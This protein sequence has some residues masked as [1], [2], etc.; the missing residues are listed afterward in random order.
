MNIYTLRTQY[1]KT[2]DRS[3]LKT[4][5]YKPTFDTEKLSQQQNERLNHDATLLHGPRNQPPTSHTH[6]L[7]GKNVY[8]PTGW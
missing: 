3:T 5:E 8:S 1:E 7:P 4:K 6:Q 2:P